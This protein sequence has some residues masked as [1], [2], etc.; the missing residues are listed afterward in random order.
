LA[1]YRRSHV[2]LG[3]VPDH[4]PTGGLW[5]NRKFA[6]IRYYFAVTS[7]ARPMYFGL[8]LCTLAEFRWC[9]ARWPGADPFNMM[10][11]LEDWFTPP[12]TRNMMHRWLHSVTPCDELR[13][14]YV[15]AVFHDG[16]C[17]ICADGV[18]FESLP[19]DLYLFG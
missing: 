11:S 8:C 4:E 10:H 15:D 14:R 19:R 6:L 7:A 18:S 5:A 17:G 13:R 1:A 3:R 2:R 12:A 16:Y 9:V